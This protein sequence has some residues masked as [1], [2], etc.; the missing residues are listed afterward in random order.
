MSD[1]LTDCDIVVYIYIYI[2][3]YLFLN[4]LFNAL[5]VIV[6]WKYTLN[7]KHIYLKSFRFQFQASF[8]FP[9]ARRKDISIWSAFPQIMAMIDDL[10]PLLIWLLLPQISF[11]RNF[12][13][14]SFQEQIWTEFKYISQPEFKLANVLHNDYLVCHC[15]AGYFFGSKKTRKVQIEEESLF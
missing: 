6:S 9:L 13:Q 4:E 3:T 2:H 7:I 15:T 10:L 8:E 5:I 14:R 12:Q 1:R 11:F